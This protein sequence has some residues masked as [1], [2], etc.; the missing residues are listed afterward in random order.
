VDR[1]ALLKANQL[2]LYIEH[3]FVFSFDADICGPD[4]GLTPD[5]IRA[6]DRY[7][8]ERFID[9]VP[10]VATFG[11]M[12]RI[13]SLP[14]YRQ[15]AEIEPSTDWSDM[16]WPQR[17][18]GFTIDTTHPDS[19]RLIERVWTDV[20]DA[21]SS[22]VVNM[23]GDEPWDLGHGKSKSA[24]KEKGTGRLYV[25]HLLR[26][27][28]WLSE[29]GRRTQFWSDVILNHL[30]LLDQRLCDATVLHWGYDENAAYDKTE[31]LTASGMDTLVCPGTCGWKRILNGMNA[32]ERNISAFASVGEALGATGLLNT[33]WGDHGHFNSLACSWHGIALGAS[34]SW[35]ANHPTGDDF[36]APFA[37]VV[38]GIEDVQ[39]IRA[40]REAARLADTHETWRLLWEP[41]KCLSADDGRPTAEQVNQLRA[42][43][44]AAIGAL[45]RIPPDCFNDSRDASELVASCR[46]NVLLASKLEWMNPAC[47]GRPPAP[48]REKREW[49]EE[50]ACL[51]GIFEASWRQR[52]KTSG[53]ADVAS[54]LDVAGRDFS[55]IRS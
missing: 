16:T 19:H 24:A 32:A 48:D 20:L 11:H 49:R 53:L 33:D 54:A 31:I 45:E 34:L 1:L 37:C 14:Q 41:L 18:R 10:A 46:F 9:L 47:C 38:L 55:V 27:H 36:D 51:G 3:A 23:C 39:P 13:L 30:D 28:L 35:R 2:Q 42:S 8:R 4:D 26:T 7:C 43:S 40:L 6:L 12:G 44:A 15:L 52:N 21:F 50:L 29:K 17:A 22:P 5:E 25:D